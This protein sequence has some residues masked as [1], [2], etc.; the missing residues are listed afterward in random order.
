MRVFYDYQKNK[1]LEF[2]NPREI[3]IQYEIER[4]K[5]KSAEISF[6]LSVLPPSLISRKLPNILGRDT[7]SA[8]LEYNIET[9]ELENIFFNG[10]QGYVSIN[11][12]KRTIGYKETFDQNPEL[13]E[14]DMVVIE[15]VSRQLRLF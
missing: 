8:I 15:L 14:C 2:Y 5:F 12:E 3:E 4:I 7:H 11:L 13:K 9:D 1:R 6:I 10:S